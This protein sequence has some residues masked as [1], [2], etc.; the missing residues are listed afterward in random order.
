MMPRILIIDD[1]KLVRETTRIVL[2]ARGY[3]VVTVDD[4]KAGIAAAEAGQFDLAIVDLFMPGIDGLKV[5]ETIRQKNP[6]LPMIVASGFMFGDKCPEMPNFD[7]MATEAGAHSTLYK[8]F[9][10]DGLLRAVEQ[11]I[12]AAA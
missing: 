11:A 8:P 7:S 6:K 2:S 5:I 1:D 12:G 3:D 4:G 9:R 10:P